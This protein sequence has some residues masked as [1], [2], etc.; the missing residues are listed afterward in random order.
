MRVT[1][2]FAPGPWKYRVD[3]PPYD[4]AEIVSTNGRVLAEG[5]RL[6]NA[7]LLAAAW[8]GFMA[9]VSAVQNHG[10]PARGIDGREYTLVRLD[11][12]YALISYVAKAKG[13]EN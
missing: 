7:A 10:G 2:P 8:D 1:S 12:F 4:R 11:D 5:I 6:E 13:E 9:A 3:H